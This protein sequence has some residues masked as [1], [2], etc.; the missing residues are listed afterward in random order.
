ML[1]LAPA[2]LW[3]GL[4][5]VVALP[6]ATAPAQ[7]RAR[8][9]S[10][11]PQAAKLSFVGLA[12]KAQVPGKLT[13]RI[14]ITGMDVAPAGQAKRNAGHHH[15]LIDTEL[16]PLDRPIPSDFNHIHFGGGQT[17]AVSHLSRLFQQAAVTEMHAVKKTEREN[18]GSIH[19]NSS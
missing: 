16:P 15:L 1:R 3:F 10:P 4:A 7:E 11:A 19:R 5:A 13:V 9:R 2:L 12:D 17:E 6:F 14:A 18:R 8:Q